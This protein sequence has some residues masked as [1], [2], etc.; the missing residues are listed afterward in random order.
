VQAPHCRQDSN[1]F[2]SGQYWVSNAAVARCRTGNSV[3]EESRSRRIVL[4]RR[5]HPKSMAGRGTENFVS[6]D[7]DRMALRR[8]GPT[9][10]PILS[11]TAIKF[12]Y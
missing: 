3:K 4:P 1:E 5:R 2:P 11:P 6:S 8:W 7:L 9:R 12:F 10:F